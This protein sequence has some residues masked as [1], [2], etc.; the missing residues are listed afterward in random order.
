MSVDHYENFPVASW[1]CPPAL[2]PAIHA[3]YRFARSADDIADEGHAS[4]EERLALL[5]GYRQALGTLENTSDRPREAC[6]PQLAGIFEPLREA[7][8]RHRLSVEPF[9]RLL[10]AFEQDVQHQAPRSREELVA[11]C[12]QSACPVGQLVLELHGVRDA[13]AQ[14]W[15]DA[16]CT[17]LQLVNFWQDLSIDLP[18]HRCYVPEQDALAHG[19]AWPLTA[20]TAHSNALEALLEELLSWSRDLLLQGAPLVHRLPGRAGW[21]LR[22]VIQGGLRIGER[23]SGNRQHCLT[24]RVALGRG[25]VLIMGLRCVGMSW[26]PRNRARI[27]E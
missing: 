21:E 22:A 3:I 27:I 4:P 9:S 12:R 6:D 20:T 23:V 15:S 14:Q 26:T 18:R 1:L 25:D 13:Q 24:S 8:E 5:S 11:Y 7:I 16:I 19:V 17:G 10:S 2:R